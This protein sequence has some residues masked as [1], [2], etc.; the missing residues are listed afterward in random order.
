[1]LIKK[2][3]IYVTAE[4]L[5]VLTKYSGLD[6]EISLEGLDYVGVERFN[7]YPKPRTISMEINV[8]F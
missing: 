2:A 1:M 6:P 8:N 5:F 4:N 7:N 3:R